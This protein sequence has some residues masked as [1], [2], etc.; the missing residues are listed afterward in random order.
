MYATQSSGSFDLKEPYYRQL[1][2]TG[3]WQQTE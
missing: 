2:P 1:N 3:S